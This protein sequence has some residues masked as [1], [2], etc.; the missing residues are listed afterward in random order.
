MIIGGIM[1]VD[2]VNGLDEFDGC[3]WFEDGKYIGH[4]D[5]IDLI[6]HYAPENKET[7]FIVRHRTLLPGLDEE[8][9][10]EFLGKSYASNISE[11]ESYLVPVEH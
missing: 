8:Q 5:Q 10:D 2:Y 11:V 6:N 1:I 9:I 7:V 3:I 4:D